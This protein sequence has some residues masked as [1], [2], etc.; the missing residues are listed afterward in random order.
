MYTSKEQLLLLACSY[1]NNT[2]SKIVLQK[3]ETLAWK[4]LIFSARI[5]SVLPMVYDALCMAQDKEQIPQEVLMSMRELAL[6]KIGVGMNKRVAFK[7]VY[8]SLK[9]RGITPFVI[10]GSA[11]ACLYEKGDLRISSDEDILI[12]E[13]EVEPLKKALADLGFELLGVSENGTVYNFL[14]RKKMLSIEVHTTLFMKE[15]NDGR[16]ASI[17]EDELLSTERDGFKVLEPTTELLFLICHAAKHFALS[18]FGIRQVMDILKVASVYH[19]EIDFELILE[20]TGKIGLHIFAA[21]LL[22]VGEEYFN[23]FKVPSCLAQYAKNTKPLLDDVLEGGVFG[24]S[25]KTRAASVRITMNAAEGNNKFPLIKALFPPFVEMVK[26]YP[27][28]EKMQLLLP[29]YWI[30]RLVKWAAVQGKD[31]LKTLAVGRKRTK[32]LKRYG[33]G[34]AG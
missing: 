34:K 20:K 26:I 1:F 27:K 31:S 14:N 16:Y 5:H 9:D 33:L 15:L 21:T 7:K 24:R 30:M 22:K 25:D 23:T 6:P 28:L 13:N 29:V 10:K 4:E 11:L 2:P 18:G 32:L 8:S 17:F 12:S 19:G 3:T